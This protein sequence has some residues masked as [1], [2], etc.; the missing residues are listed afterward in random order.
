MADVSVRQ[1]TWALSWVSKLLS[2]VVGIDER[3]TFKLNNFT[4]HIITLYFQIHVSTFLGFIWKK[5]LLTPLRNSESVSLSPVLVVDKN[6]NRR[7]VYATKEMNKLLDTKLTFSCYI[8]YT[9]STLWRITDTIQTHPWN[10]IP[11]FIPAHLPHS[12]FMYILPPKIFTY[13]KISAYIHSYFLVSN[14]WRF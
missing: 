13:L 7:T 9:A 8:G 12:I 14:A 11:S 1:E 6:S 4:R 10:E 2:D 3:A 5:I